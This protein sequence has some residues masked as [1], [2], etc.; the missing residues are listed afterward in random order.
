MITRDEAIRR[1]DA[2]M[3]AQLHRF[4]SA[5]AQ[6]V[7]A[8]ELDMADAIEAQEFCLAQMPESRRAAIQAMDDIDQA[9]RNEAN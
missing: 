5:L 9:F 2:A 1:L 3:E 6:T 7:V 8:G 4:L